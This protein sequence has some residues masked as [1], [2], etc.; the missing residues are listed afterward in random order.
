MTEIL[1]GEFEVK[2]PGD[3]TVNFR[4]GNIA[5]DI[6]QC[7]IEADDP[8]AITVMHMQS[9]NIMA[10]LPQE[11]V[12]V[13]AF[14]NLPLKLEFRI[15]VHVHLCLR[16]SRPVRGAAYAAVC[17]VEQPKPSPRYT[18]GLVPHE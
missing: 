5:G 2:E 7:H 10:I 8:A 18:L 3:V 13:C 1:R 14:N 12:P 11:G 4:G 15:A 6:V 17:P 9:G 16:V